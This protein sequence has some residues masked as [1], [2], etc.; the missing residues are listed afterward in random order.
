MNAEPMDHDIVIYTD[1]AARGNPGISASGFIVTSGEGK[2]LA[3]RSFY[4]GIKTNN[5]AE[6]TAVI[7]A[8]EWC[9]NHIPQ[10]EDKR[11]MLVSDSELVI[12]QLN[13][14]YKIK[15]EEMRML[16]KTVAALRRHFAKVDF[17]NRRR[18][19]KGISSVD[20]ALNA[21]LDNVETKK[22]L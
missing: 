11:I 15:S 2:V 4:N 12:R 3:K 7:K 17:V 16:N 21:L 8:L 14:E 13:G 19:D 22:E 20:R 1:G 6:Y 18:S 9:R 5:Y 10:H